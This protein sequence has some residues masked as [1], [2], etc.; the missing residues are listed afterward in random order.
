MTPQLGDRSA[1]STL[2]W[3]IYANFAA[4]GPLPDPSVA[5]MREVIE[6]QAREGLSFVGPWMERMAD[7]R[8]AAG[9][10][11]GVPGTDI[12]LMGNTSHGVSAIAACLPWK[13]GDRVLLF[14]GEFPTN[15]TPWELAAKHH[16]LD[17]VWLPA[18][19]LRTDDGLQQV[20][21]ECRRGLRLIAVSAVQFSTGLR[22]P[23]ES[24]AKLAHAHG[25]E[26]FVDAIQAVGSVPLD[27]SD[28]DYLSA[29]GQKWLMGPVGT[30]LLYVR[31]DLWS[32]L[33]PRLASWLSHPEPLGFLFGDP[34][35]LSYGKPVV[36]GPAMF[37]GGSICIA[38]HAALGVSMGMLADLGPERI[39]AHVQAWH[40]AVEPGLVARGFRSLRAELSSR[41]SGLLCCKPPEGQHA[42]QLVA[43]LS[44]HGV[45]VASPDATLRLSPSWPNPL[46]EAEGVLTA[47]DAVLA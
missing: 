36:A 6:A 10:L 15:T 17:L 46:S 26:I 22:M 12:A 31:H 8:A 43:A 4:I 13:R 14:T 21:D 20:E 30:G 38:G 42:G 33:V 29:G 44:E 18:D 45:S 35:L 27:L 9:R 40:D 3:P 34:D 32:A 16:D 23:V 37:E 47:V 2:R 25:A 19:S 39:A 24:L 11:M 7:T 28:V 41:R 5:V 1:F